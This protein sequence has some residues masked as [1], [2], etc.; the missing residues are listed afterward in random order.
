MKTIDPDPGKIA[1]ALASIPG[2]EPVVML[3]LLRFRDR[4][5][6]D[7]AES[8]CS[9]REAYQR[10]GERAIAH[11]KRVGAELVWHGDARIALIAPPG[12]EWDEILL[13]RYPSIE[14]FVEMVTNAEYRQLAK[15]RTAA[16]Q[17]ARLIASL[18][19]GPR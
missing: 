17:D 7:G 14:K 2:G 6:Y 10:Y 15:H 5:L 1:E 16:L 4:A 11:L 9:G 12:E 18:E 19:S 3:N 8:D 13:V